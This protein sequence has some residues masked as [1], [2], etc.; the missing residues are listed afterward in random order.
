VKSLATQKAIIQP[1][2][3][4]SRSQG[5]LKIRVCSPAILLS[6]CLGGVRIRSSAVVPLQPRQSRA[7]QPAAIGAEHQTGVKERNYVR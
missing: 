3:P 5:C 2:Q 1:R 6:F 4:N 7:Q